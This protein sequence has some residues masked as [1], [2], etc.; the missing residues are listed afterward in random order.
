MN[1]SVDLFCPCQSFFFF[2]SLLLFFPNVGQSQL[3]C[4]AALSSIHSVKLNFLK[5][6][7][8]GF[9]KEFEKQ[10]EVQMITDNS[11]M[12]CHEKSGLQVRNFLF[13]MHQMS[14]WMSIQKVDPT[15]FRFYWPFTKNSANFSVKSIIFA[16]KSKPKWRKSNKNF[17]EI[18]TKNQI[19]MLWKFIYSEKVR[20]SHNFDKISQLMWILISKI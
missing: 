19:W 18:C 11:F 15:S 3:S 16:S 13:L 20:K 10:N 12:L 17:K 1:A 6:F 14:N 7:D 5:K 8:S 9:S 2:F 4:T